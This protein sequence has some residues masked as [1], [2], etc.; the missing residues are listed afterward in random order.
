[1][2]LGLGE[3]A[4]VM[5]AVCWSFA[6]ICFRVAG[7][8]IRSFP[9]TVFKTIAAAAFFLLAL[10]AWRFVDASWAWVLALSPR[11]WVLLVASAFFASRSGTSFHHGAQRLG[12]GLVASWTASTPR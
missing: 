11:E 2:T 6:V 1:M 8:E 4:A 3:C 5:T 7:D 9:L 12:A 10:V